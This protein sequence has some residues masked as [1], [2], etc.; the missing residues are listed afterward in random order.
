MSNRDDEDKFRTII[1]RR[2]TELLSESEVDAV[3][4]APPSS[5]P[6]SEAWLR[7]EPNDRGDFDQRYTRRGFLARGGMGELEILHDL[8]IGREVVAKF[9]PPE[10]NTDLE[11]RARFTR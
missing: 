9:L 10:R 6:L 3:G 11:Y 8:R 2:A 1:E 4:S 5:T 7:V